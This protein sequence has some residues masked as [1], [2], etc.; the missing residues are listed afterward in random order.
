M[1]VTVPTSPTWSSL[2]PTDVLAGKALTITEMQQIVRHQHYL[3]SRLGFRPGG[4]IFRKSDDSPWKTTSTSYVTASTNSHPYSLASW[5]GFGY[6]RRRTGST[7]AYD[8]GFSAYG[9]YIDVQVIIKRHDGGFTTNNIATLSASTDS[10]N[11]E[12]ISASTSTA[13]ASWHVSGSTANP[14]AQVSFLVSA[15]IDTGATAE[16]FQLVPLEVITTSSDVPTI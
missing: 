16:L 13:E 6:V 7:L 8:V 9:R 4:V 1:S 12:W 5:M 2:D 3:W 10:G 14:L 15:K 11:Y